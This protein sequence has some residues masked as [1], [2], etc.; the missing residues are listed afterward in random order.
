MV[1]G[2]C[3]RYDDTYDSTDIKL[4]GTVELHMFDE[5][6]NLVDERRAK[7]VEVVSFLFLFGF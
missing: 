2:G 3:F 5:D 4:A 1:F 7:R 6:E